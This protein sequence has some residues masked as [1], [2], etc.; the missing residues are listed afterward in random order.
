MAV[1]TNFRI[2]R[3]A[4]NGSDWPGYPT[5]VWVGQGAVAG[6]GSGGDIQARFLFQLSAEALSAQL[7]SL[8]QL[9]VEFAAISIGRQLIMETRNMGR[10]TTDRPMANRAWQMPVIDGIAGASQDAMRSDALPRTIFLGAPNAPAV[11]CALLFATLNA[12]GTT[13]TAALWGYVWD[14]GALNAPGGLTK[15]ADALWR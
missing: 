11:E 9:S 7:Y 12:T 13:L 8:E 14:P 3:Q 10:L 6:D 5:G 2:E 1:A 4:W 15:P